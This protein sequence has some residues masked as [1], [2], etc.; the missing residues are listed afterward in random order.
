MVVVYKVNTMIEF[1]NNEEFCRWNGVEMTEEEQLKQFG[2]IYN[3]LQGNMWHINGHIYS[4]QPDYTEAII[5]FLKSVS[6]TNSETTYDNALE[7]AYG[8]GR[9]VETEIVKINEELFKSIRK[10]KLFSE[11]PDSKNWNLSK[12][13]EFHNDLI[14]YYKKYEHNSIT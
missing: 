11:E 1:I 7:Y 13:L 3:D 5:D 2:A 14:Q 9:L 4:N 10:I 12:M 6:Y 8:F